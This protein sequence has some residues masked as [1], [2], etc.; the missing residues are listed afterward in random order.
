MTA[1]RRGAAWSIDAA[2]DALANLEPDKWTHNT[3]SGG[4]GLRI[5]VARLTK[6]MRRAIKTI[7]NRYSGDFSVDL[8]AGKY[9][10]AAK[11]A[12]NLAGEKNTAET[13]MPIAASA[14]KFASVQLSLSNWTRNVGPKF[15]PAAV[16]RPPS[17]SIDQLDRDLEI[18]RQ[19]ADQY[20]LIQ[21]IGAGEAL[22]AVGVLIFSNTFVGSLEDY[23]TVFLWGFV[24]DVGVNNML[25]LVRSKVQT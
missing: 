7:A 6:A 14:Q 21:T 10:D 15:A 8:N 18:S 22:I 17:W 24:T 25:T 13:D 2:R 9:V 5:P 3:E 4:E 20:E 23:L 1:S 16:T 12:Y 19:K 11:A